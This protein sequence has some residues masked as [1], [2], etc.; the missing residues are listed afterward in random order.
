MNTIKGALRRIVFISSLLVVLTLI[1]VAPVQAQV[2]PLPEDTNNY[3]P[4]TPEQLA[5]MYAAWLA[6]LS[7]NLVSVQEWLH[8]GYTLP[9][10]TPADFQTIMDQSAATYAAGLP[11][12]WQQSSLDSAL[13]WANAVGAPT[14]IP[15]AD[16][17]TAFLVSIDEGPLYTMPCNVEAAQTISTTNVWPGGSAGLSLTGTNRT[18]FMWDEGMPRLTHSEFTSRASMLDVTVT[19]LSSHSTAVAGTLMA[20]GVN[21]VYSNGVPIGPAAKGMSFAGLVQAGSFNKDLQQMPQQA[22]TN[23]MRLSNH[24]YEHSTGWVYAGS[25]VWYWFGYSQVNTNKDSKFGNYSVYSAS[26]DQIQQNVP[27]YLG[28][29]ASGNDVSNAPPVQ[30]TNHY[31]LGSSGYFVTNLVH[32]ANGD[33]GGYDTV[34]DYGCAKNTLTVGAIYPIY[35]G[36][37]GP[38]GVVWAP[39]SSCGPTDDG[40]IK[41]DVTAAGV[42]IITTDSANDYAYQGTSGT[43]FST[44]SV[45]GS[46]NL[47]GQH[48]RQLHPNAPDLLSST[49][50]GLVIHTADSAT[51]N[52]GPT[53]RFGY[54]LMNTAK[55]SGLLGNDATNGFRNFI[56]EVMMTNGQYIQFP[57]V[58]TG[59]AGN[60]LSITMCWTDPAGAG[61][62]L[63]NLDNP[64]IK[65]VNDLDLRVVS[66]NGTTNL[67]WILN[68]DLT[69]R[70]SA[71][72]SAAAT[73]GD[74][75]RNNVEQVYIA[76]PASGTYT[77]RVTHKGT[78]TNSQWVSIL[79]SGNVAQQAPPLVI[80]QPLQV[81]TNLLAIGWPAVVGGR[82]QVQYINGLSTS[83][84]WQNVG[85][86]ISARLTNVVATV[87]YSR[88]NAPQFFRVVGLP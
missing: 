8:D 65:L 20:G 6:S 37:S 41:P 71:A 28:V 83:N 79:I 39:F 10:G 84:Y 55:A 34:S 77:V 62:A 40:R 22:G 72:R 2:P 61:N 58:S 67:P 19:N 69:N 50:K 68:P 74:D 59:G 48:Y 4:P 42:A 63:T 32:S 35:G 73:T 5:A 14:Q 60:P 49:F 47:L 45:A 7:N 44:P 9:D 54:G 80:N 51:N 33:A 81:A 36:Y 53:Y 3:P 15:L 29:W 66:P 27:N 16:G 87:P 1:S 43:S 17:T 46:I 23:Y 25:G 57:I 21:T 78:L 56:K 52:L 30:P 75:N 11:N 12:S 13:T 76:S 31:E 26:V 64:A 88:T 86:Q 85:A 82:Y 70:T 24:S 38:T 18:L